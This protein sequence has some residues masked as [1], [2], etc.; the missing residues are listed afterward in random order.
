M[1]ASTGSTPNLSI[2]FS[3]LALILSFTKRPSAGDHSRLDCMF[4]SKTRLDLLFAWDTLFPLSG[5]FPVTGQTFDIRI[6]QRG[7][8]GKRGNSLSSSIHHRPALAK[9]RPAGGGFPGTPIA[10]PWRSRGVRRRRGT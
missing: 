2:I 3:P 10:D 5:R 7:Y 4:G 8:R 9:S 1:S 6:L